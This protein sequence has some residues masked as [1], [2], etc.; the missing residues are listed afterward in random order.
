MT[1]FGLFQRR[2]KTHIEE[3]LV[4]HSGDGPEMC[5]EWRQF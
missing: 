4:L 1:L 3:N 2:V 5:D